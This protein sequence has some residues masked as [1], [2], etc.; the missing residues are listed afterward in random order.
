MQVI[1]MLAISAELLPCVILNWK[2]VP[3]ALQHLELIV[4]FQTKG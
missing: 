3:K 1:M 2:T 4:M